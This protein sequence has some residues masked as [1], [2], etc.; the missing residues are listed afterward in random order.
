MGITKRF[1]EWDNFFGGLGID[2]NF[3]LTDSKLDVSRYSSAGALVATDRTTLPNQS[4]ILFNSAV[5]Y[6]KYGFMFKI[7]G[8]YRGN[9]IETINQNLGPDY[10]ISAKSNFTVDLSADY[11]INDKIKVFMEVRNITNEPFKLYL[12]SNQNRI[13]SSEWSS[14]NGQIGVKFQIF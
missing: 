13:T 1:T 2:L 12:G 3:T 10:Y 5:F 14:I 11:S 9:A 8:N 6:E 7:A 4:K